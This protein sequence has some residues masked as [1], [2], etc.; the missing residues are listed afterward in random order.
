MSVVVLQKMT[1]INPIPYNLFAI[2]MIAVIVIMIMN[3][4]YPEVRR[5]G[6][7]GG[8]ATI[9]LQIYFYPTSRG[10]AAVFTVT[11]TNGRPE[12]ATIKL[13]FEFTKKASGFPRSK[14]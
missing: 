13:L 6:M 9:S 11:A 10:T 5:P 8:K 4:N 2:R 3:A 12:T 14:Q 1:S 7:R